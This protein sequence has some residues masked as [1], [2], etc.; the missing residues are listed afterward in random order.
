MA[1]GTGQHPTTQMALVALQE[2]IQPD[3]HVLDLGAGSG[4][5]AIAAIG[6]GAD[7]AIAVD[8][9]VQ[10]YEACISNAALNGMQDNIRSV[11][12]SLDDV[13]A[14][15][16]FDLILANINA[17]TVTRLAQG[18]HDALK[19]GCYVVAGGII[20]ERVPGCVDALRLPASPSSARS[21]TATGAAS[22]VSATSLGN[23]LDGPSDTLS[24]PEARNGFLSLRAHRHER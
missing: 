11:H 8:T 6:L 18:I 16:P 4:V 13:S 17:A 9:E 7:D 22:S 10:A 19:P 20:E 21:R 23:A 15:G 3:A 5:L 2:L 12:G 14:D 24:R 1:F